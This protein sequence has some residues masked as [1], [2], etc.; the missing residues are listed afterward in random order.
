MNAFDKTSSPDISLGL[1]LGTLARKPDLPLVFRYDGQVVRPGYH[2]TEVKAGQFSGLDCGANPEAWAEIFV[3]LW[4]VEDGGR[5]HMQAGKFAA[6]IRK[7]SEHVKLDGSARL[8]FEVSDGVRP[9][10]LYCAAMPQ[11]GETVIS[12]ELAPRPASCKPR[13]RWLAEQ[14][15]ATPK[16]CCTPSSTGCC[17]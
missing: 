4:D 16:P 6:I 5:T 10:A 7:V 17:A 3:Q 13:D 12:V 14:E 11:V 8:T 9:M 15:T 2:V 1:L